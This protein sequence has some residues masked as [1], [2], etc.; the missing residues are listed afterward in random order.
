MRWSLRNRSIGLAL[1]L[2]LAGCATPGTK[3]PDISSDLTAREKRAQQALHVKRVTSYQTRLQRI[4]APLLQAALPFCQGEETGYVGA[5]VDNID[6]WS[7]KHQSIARD[8][9]NLDHA[10]KIT[11]IT[12]GSP[13]HGAGLQ[14]G[15]L[16]LSVNGHATL[17]G[18]GAVEDFNHLLSRALNDETAET[19]RIEISR[20]S[21]PMTMVVQPE[22]MCDYAVHVWMNN[23]INAFADGG[24]IVVTSGLMRFAES[25]DEV[26]LVVAHEIAHNSM[27]HIE[28]KAQNA[29]LA[30]VFDILA[31]A[32]GVNTSGLFAKLGARS[33]S[34]E[35]EREADYLGLYIMA[36]AGEPVNGLGGFWR[37]M[38]AED[39]ASNSTSIFRTHPI[40]AERSLALRQ[41]GRAHV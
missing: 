41:I 30:S 7:D 32:Y 39:P 3:R 1:I 6:A 20:N 28:A 38:A 29:R 40:S 25:D 33:F 8:V 26:A 27:D 19:V 15:D 16:L 13:A 12:P 24:N 37:R 36:R 11:L 2:G 31:A 9:L 34:K 18:Q 14:K 21:Q 4:S 5:W 17:G 35:F 22:P 23:S 10:L